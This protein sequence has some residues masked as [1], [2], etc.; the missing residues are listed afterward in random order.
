MSAPTAPAVPLLRETLL[1]ALGDAIE[2]RQGR[3]AF[4]QPCA[5]APDGL[6]EDHR[7]DSAAAADYEAAR[8]IIASA[9]GAT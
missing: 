3:F 1:S 6:C 5:I 9:I 2:Y 8:K 7:E 4:C